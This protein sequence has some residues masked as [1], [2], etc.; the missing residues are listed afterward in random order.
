MA[1]VTTLVLEQTITSFEANV[2]DLTPRTPAR[3]AEL[4]VGAVQVAV[5]ALPLIGA[6]VLISSRRL[7]AFRYTALAVASRP[8]STSCCPNESPDSIRPR[9]QPQ[10]SHSWLGPAHFPGGTFLAAATAAIA[11]L[12]PSSTAD[13]AGWPG[14]ACGS[15]CSSGS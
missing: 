14:S 5:V 1:V 9:T 10:P 11:V 4:F 12:T 7:R 15:R 2:L 6:L 8:G 3:V 13:R